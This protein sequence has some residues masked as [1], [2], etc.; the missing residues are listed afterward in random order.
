MKTTELII[1]NLK[2]FVEKAV[3]L[4]KYPSNTGAGYLAAIKTAE[5]ALLDDEPKTIDYLL[6]HVEELFVRQNVKLSPQSIPVYVGR[7]KTVSSDYKTYGVDGAAIYKWTRGSRKRATKT[8]NNK[9]NNISKAENQDG[10]N[11]TNNDWSV[12]SMPNESGVKLNLVSWRLRPGLMIRIELPEDI[13]E[14][15]VN[16]IKAL[17]D[18]ELKFGH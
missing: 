6:D 4:G 18:V 14:Q 2:A 16:K 9:E 12:P 10:E 3:K 5:R 7:I 13:S 1:D 11:L 15:D 17:L 8:K